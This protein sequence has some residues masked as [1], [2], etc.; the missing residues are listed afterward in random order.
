MNPGLIVLRIKYTH[1][2][3]VIKPFIKALKLE[4]SVIRRI[5]LPKIGVRQTPTPLKVVTP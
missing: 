5:K 1:V 2:K 4:K 3:S